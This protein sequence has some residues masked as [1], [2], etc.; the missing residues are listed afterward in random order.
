MR[1][2]HRLFE[3]VDNKPSKIASEWVEFIEIT[4][5]QS[6]KIIDRLGRVRI[7]RRH[8]LLDVPNTTLYPQMTHVGR[9]EEVDTESWK[10]STYFD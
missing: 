8:T 9:S 1:T 7:V 10:K 3:Y 4:G 2:R 6:A 5:S